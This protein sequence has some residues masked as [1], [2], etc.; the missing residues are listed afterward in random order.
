MAVVHVHKD[1]NHALLL[2]EQALIVLRTVAQSAV[3]LVWQLPLQLAQTF[4]LRVGTVISKAAAL[5]A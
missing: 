4:L 3:A 2:V 5:I 1:T